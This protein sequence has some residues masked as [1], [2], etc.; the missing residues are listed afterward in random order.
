MA[1][2]NWTTT[3]KNIDSIFYLN[4]DIWWNKMDIVY[5]IITYFGNYNERNESS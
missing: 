3:E 5:F 4:L 1:Y 2:T